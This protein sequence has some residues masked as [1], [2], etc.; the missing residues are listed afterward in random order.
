MDWEDITAYIKWLNQLTGQSYRLPT[1]AEWE[2]AAR[3]STTTYYEW[4][5]KIGSNKA[6]CDGCQS[7]WDNQQT[8][9]VGSFTPNPYGLYDMVGNVWEWTCSNYEEKYSG[10]E[11]HCGTKRHATLGVIRGGSWL[12]YPKNVRIANRSKS[13]LSSRQNYVGFRI[14]RELP[15]EKN[16]NAVANDSQS[17]AHSN[18]HLMVGL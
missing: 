10:W 16:L 15:P 17:K 13:E 12:S 14:V 4:G 11:Q 9:P 6:N 1:E 18:T 5:N 8:A 2:Y 3:A 7:R